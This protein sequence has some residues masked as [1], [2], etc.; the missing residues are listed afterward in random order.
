[1]GG[2]G[3]ALG[4]L[5]LTLFCTASWVVWL[6]VATKVVGFGHP[7]VTQPEEPLCLRAQVVCAL[8]FLILAGCAMPVP[9]RMVIC[10][11]YLCEAL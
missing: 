7:E 4:L 5:F 8:C 2:P 9:I 6:V 1:M 10:V 3:V 11:R